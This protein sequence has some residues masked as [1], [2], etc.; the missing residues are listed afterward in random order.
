MPG[1]FLWQILGRPDGLIHNVI[2]LILGISHLGNSKK[3]KR[4]FSWCVVRSTWHVYVTRYA[5][6]TT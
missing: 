1:L 3:I 2:L 4:Q 6:R 5:P